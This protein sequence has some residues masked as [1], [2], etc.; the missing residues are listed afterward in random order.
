MTMNEQGTVAGLSKSM[1]DAFVPLCELS[2]EQYA[3]LAESSEL[4]NLFSGQDLV[5]LGD[6]QPSHLYLVHGTLLLEDI[7]GHKREI[8]SSDVDAKLPISHIFPRR[9]TVSASSDAQVLKVPSELLEKMLCW[10][11][12]ARCLLAEV[13]KDADYEEGYLWIKRLFQSRLF[14]KVPPTNILGVLNSFIALNVNAGDRV[15]EE[16]DE[17]S[18]CYLIKSGEAD[19][20]LGGNNEPVATL[21]VGSVFGEDALVNNMPRNASVVM[22]S[23]GILMKLE[24]QA[25]YELLKQP[26]VTAIAAAS[27]EGLLIKGTQLID[28]RTQAE[29]DSGHHVKAMNLPLSLSYL[30]S[31]LLDREKQYIAYSGSEDRAKTGAFLLSQ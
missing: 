12:V 26:M 4:V 30:K 5:K 11:Q 8:S 29:F 9:S 3:F 23:D 15:I 14:Y 22:R 7:S 10:G 18:C 24:K 19:V 6:T 21:N 17:G 25:F 27:V 28:V 16:G 13:A 31:A 2:E 20:F 1:V